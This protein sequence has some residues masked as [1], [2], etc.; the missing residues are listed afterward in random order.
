MRTP[1]PVYRFI[2]CAKLTDICGSLINIFNLRNKNSAAENCDSKVSNIESC[3]PWSVMKDVESKV[4]SS[5]KTASTFLKNNNPF[6]NFAARFK[7]ISSK[8]VVEKADKLR[9]TATGHVEKMVQSAKTGGKSLADSG[10]SLADT[11]KNLAGKAKQF[12]AKV[13]ESVNN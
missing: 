9:Q 13:K 4:D 6:A 1:Y 5:L 10:K 12:F 8:S 2:V 3:D 11:G 7:N